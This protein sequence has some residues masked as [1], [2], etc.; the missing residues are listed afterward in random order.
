MVT[1]GESILH[2]KVRRVTAS[3]YIGILEDE[4]QINANRNGTGYKSIS[5][6]IK[7]TTFRGTQSASSGE[8]M[9]SEIDV[10]GYGNNENDV[11]NYG[12]A[13]R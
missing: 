6:F 3:L 1:A 4:T 13:N 9:W 2:E 11:T 5:F 12:R 7:I 8:K 10:G